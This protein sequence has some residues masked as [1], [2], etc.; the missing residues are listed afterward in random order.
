VSRYAPALLA[1]L[2][3]LVLLAGR[4]PTVRPEPVPSQGSEVDQAFA[5]QADLYTVGITG[6]IER[7][8]SGQLTTDQQARDWLQ[9]MADQARRDAWMPVAQRDAAALNPWSVEVQVKRL[10]EMI[11]E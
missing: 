1:A 9:Q 7:L 10:Q 5:R 11:R 8:Q 3:G 6:A 4:Q 2:G